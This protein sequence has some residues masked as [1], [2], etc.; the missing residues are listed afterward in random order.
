LV[1][2]RGKKKNSGGGIWFL[3]ERDGTPAKAPDVAN[4]Y[5]TGFNKVF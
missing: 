3:E 5:E 2:G 4:Q 1:S